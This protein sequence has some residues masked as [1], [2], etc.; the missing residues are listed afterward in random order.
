VVTK[1]KKNPKALDTN[2]IL[3]R[4]RFLF[5]FNEVDE[6]SS[7]KLVKD[8][9]AL[10]IKNKGK[11]ITL[12]INSPGGSCSDGLAIIDTITK[13]KSPVVT[14][15]T[16]EACSMAGIISVVGDKRL[17]TSSSRWMGHPITAGSYDYL[18]HVKDR[19]KAAEWI[20]DLCMDIFKKHTNLS[21]KDIQKTQHGELWL[22]AEECLLKGIV[23]KIV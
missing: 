10:D 6:D 23:D 15:V 5:L 14:I 17:M 4:N 20:E 13:I 19:V 11:Q 9:L 7:R 16:G 21:E 22:S 12:W 8:L 3:L 18:P 2:D 1:K